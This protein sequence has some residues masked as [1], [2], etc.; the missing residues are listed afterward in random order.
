MI[1]MISDIMLMTRHKY[2]CFF[3]CLLAFLA[4]SL[5]LCQES[6]MS[7]IEKTGKA[8]N[9]IYRLRKSPEKALVKEIRKSIKLS[10]NLLDDGTNAYEA[11]KGDNET[12]VYECKDIILVVIHI[13]DIQDEATDFLEG[14]AM[15]DVVR[16][17]RT[18]YRLPEK[19][20]YAFC[21]I[22]NHY[23]DDKNIYDYV[24]AIK[25]EELHLGANKQ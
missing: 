10:G 11:I 5:T 18:F 8:D 22:Q 17:L 7:T 2:T 24:V 19:L 16:Q 15:L 20:K 12:G 3:A 25:R 14:D 21:C 13:I 9:K 23:D 6:S 1:M 4:S